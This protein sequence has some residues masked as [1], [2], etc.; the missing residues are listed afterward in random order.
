VE[1]SGQFHAPA[2]LSLEKSHVSPL[3][4]RMTE[5][6]N[7][8]GYRKQS[9]LSSESNRY[10]S[11]CRPSPGRITIQGWAVGIKNKY[12]PLKAEYVSE[13]LYAVCCLATRLCKKRWLKPN[14]V[15]LPFREF[16]QEFCQTCI[17]YFTFLVLL[18][19][20]FNF[21]SGWGLKN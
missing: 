15:L 14:N 4:G 19:P 6:P 13:G 16:F 5:P 2:A 10:S 1:E 11:V 18:T 7:Q 12:I 8:C 9:Y 21:I 20:S 3:D 17:V